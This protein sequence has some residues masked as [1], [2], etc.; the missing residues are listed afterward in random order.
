MQI[1]ARNNQM[2]KRTIS[3][4]CR[5][6]LNDPRTLIRAGTLRIVFICWH[7]V[8]QSVSQWCPSSAELHSVSCH[9]VRRKYNSA[10]LTHF[11]FCGI[12]CHL[13]SSEGSLS[14]PLLAVPPVTLQRKVCTEL[15]SRF[16]AWDAH[17]LWFP[18]GLMSDFHR[19]PCIIYLWSQTCE[20]SFMFLNLWLFFFFFYCI[21]FVATK[22]ECIYAPL[23]LYQNYQTFIANVFNFMLR[24]SERNPLQMV[25]ACMINHLSR[26]S[27]EAR[28]RILCT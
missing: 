17:S 22:D 9:E 11:L 8:S 19:S 15:Q 26:K 20:P 14:T 13:I 1:P 21:W 10:C 23:F 25:R 12:L 6:P 16:Y 7:S 3:Q 24:F 18:W 4:P 2:L 27:N 5:Y 28:Q